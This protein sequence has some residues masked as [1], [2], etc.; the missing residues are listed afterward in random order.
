MTIAVQR[1][2]AR[3]GMKVQC[4]AGAR[5]FGASARIDGAARW[6]CWREWRRRRREGDDAGEDEAREE[7][8][9]EEGTFGLRETGRPKEESGKG[10]G[11]FKLEKISNSNKKPKKILK[12]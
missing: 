7:N 4:G 10:L 12:S 6:Q 8:A 3:G 11:I 2:S 9:L 1:A 5:R